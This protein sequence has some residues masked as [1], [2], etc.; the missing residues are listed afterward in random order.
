ME[1]KVIYNRYH[2]IRKL[3]QGGNAEVFL[4]ED[5]ILKKQ[6]AVKILKTP[7]EEKNDE[8]LLYK[9][10]IKTMA[11]LT[12]QNIVKIYDCGIDQSHPFVVM[13]YVKGQS[14]RAIIIQRGFLMIEEFKQY[15]NQI[16][17]GL[18]CAHENQ[19][20]H[21]DIKPQNIIVK[22][23]GVVTI[24]DFGTAYILDKKFNAYD[25]EKCIGSVHYMAPE[26]PLEKI[27]DERID[28]YSLGI[29]MFEMLTGKLPFVDA[30]PEHKTQVEKYKAVIRMHKYTPLPSA[31]KYNPQITEEIE[32]IINKACSKNRESRYKSCRQI[33][34]DL[35]RAYDH[36]LHPENCH[37]QQSWIKK[38]FS[39]KEKKK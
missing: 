39:R 23:N 13:E 14:L 17:D 25:D 9:Q 21:R 1:S 22:S 18:I 15:M 10:E 26:Y 37:K 11:T 16:L 20:I 12:H 3:G 8:Y 35:Q 33:K 28:I 24:I 30:N 32:Q 29:T 27:S 6:V 19:I 5:Q 7:V 31:R 38:L 2:L 4:A 36:Y 34:E